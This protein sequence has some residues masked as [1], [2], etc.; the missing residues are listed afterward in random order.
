MIS[1]RLE[2]IQEGP[3]AGGCKRREQERAGDFERFDPLRTP[4][5]HAKEENTATED[6]DSMDLWSGVVTVRRARDQSAERLNAVKSALFQN[7]PHDQP[8]LL[9][10]LLSVDRATQ[11]LEHQGKWLFRNS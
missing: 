4:A 1:C 9:A 7:P 6:V 3:G 10:V 2:S 8:T 5:G 11:S